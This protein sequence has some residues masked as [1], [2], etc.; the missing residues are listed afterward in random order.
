MT[1]HEPCR[2]IQGLAGHL[3]IHALLPKQSP[4]SPQD[5]VFLGVVGMVLARDLEDG[6]EGGRVRVDAM[7]DLVRNLERPVN[8]VGALLVP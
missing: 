3:Q 6:G 4:Y 1:L 8:I 7:S 2:G 5:T